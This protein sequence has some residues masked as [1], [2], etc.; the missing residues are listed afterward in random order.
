MPKVNTVVAER[1]EA[2]LAELSEVEQLRRILVLIGGTLKGWAERHGYGET[3][4]HLTLRGDRPYLELRDRMA[5]DTGWSRV[6]IDRAIQEEK[7]R[8]EAERA[9][10]VPA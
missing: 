3:Q 10:R 1:V 8:R 5:D 6:R 2:G 7:V 9:E 4:V